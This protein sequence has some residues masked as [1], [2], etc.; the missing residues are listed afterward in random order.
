M[1]AWKSITI[2]M[3]KARWAPFFLANLE[4]PGIEAN[5]QSQ[6]RFTTK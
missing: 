4:H 6:L 2:R 3:E 1:R 5:I